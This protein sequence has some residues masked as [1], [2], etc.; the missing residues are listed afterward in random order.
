GVEG[1]RD[2]TVQERRPAGPPVFPGE[3]FVPVAPVG[4]DADRDLAHQGEVGHGDDAH[5]LA[6]HPRIAVAVAEGVELL[7]VAEG[8]GGL[9]VDPAAQA[10]V[11]GA[12]VLRIERTE[13]QGLVEQPGG[14]F[15]SGAQ[16]EDARHFVG[17]RRD[18]GVETDGDAR[19]RS[20]AGHLAAAKLSAAVW[21][22]SR[23][24]IW[25]KWPAQTA[26]TSA[27]SGARPVTRSIDVMPIPLRPQGMMPAK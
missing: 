20:R 18:D 24:K 1:G 5:P 8:E 21:Q 14:A 17:D 12:V 16:G 3:E 23:S 10:T 22:G 13:G 2:G 26:A 19:L 27:R 9:L 4:F 15:A 25:A 11:E 6:A 7:D